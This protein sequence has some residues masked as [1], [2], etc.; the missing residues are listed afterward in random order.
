MIRGVIF[1]LDGTIYR[2]EALI[3]GAAEALEALA[4]AGI[5]RVFLSNKPL[6][7]PCAYAAKLTRLGIPTSPAEVINSARVLAVYLRQAM[8]GARLFVVGE[9]PLKEEL[10]EAGL[11]IVEDSAAVDCVVLAFDRT[12]DYR[13]LNLAFQAVKYHGARLVATNADRSCPVD[14]GEVPDAAGMIAAVEAT[15]GR[16]VELVAGKPSPLVVE[17][18][19]AHLGV[20][21]EEALM[22]G[23]R[24]ETDMAMGRS[25]GIRTALVLSGV[26]SLRDLQRS[27]ERPDYVWESVADLPAALG[28]GEARLA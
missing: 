7:R 8:P 10:A 23:D 6:E 1:D 27:A 20:Q 17:A 3:P 2:G 9:P 21:P 16:K 11:R 19:L 15:T 18:A 26:T 28:L 12:F 4:G 13:K 14:G 24:L 25:A 22:V 5:G